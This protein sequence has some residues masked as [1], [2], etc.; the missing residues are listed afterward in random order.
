[1]SIPP[2]PGDLGRRLL[3]SVVDD[4]ARS[5]P[6]R[7]L[8]SMPKTRSPRDGFQDITAV[9]FSQAVDRCAWYL[10]KQL[11][12]G[13]GFPT[14]LYIGPQDLV[15]AILILASIKVGYKLLL[16]SPRNTLEAHVHL[17]KETGCGTMLVPTGFP[18]P[19]IGKI[20]ETTGIRR[21]DLPGA[22]HWLCDEAVEAYP[23]HKTYEEARLEPW[24]ALHTSGST[25]MPKPIIQ[26]HA[27]Y[28]P[29]DAYTAL[30][31]LGLPRTFP[32]FPEG[33]RVYLGFPLF[34]CGGLFV[35]LPCSIFGNF[36]VVLGPFPPSSEVIQQ[37]HDHGNVEE[38]LIPPSSLADM[39]KDPTYIEGLSRLNRITT[40]GGPLPREVGNTISS[41]TGLANILGSTEA[42][43]IPLEVIDRE[44][45]AYMRVSP[46]YGAEF[47][48]VSEDLYEQVIVRRPELEPYQGVFGTFP[49]LQEWPMKDLYSKHPTKEGLWLY[50][51]RTDDIIVFSTGEKLN[52]LDMEDII[53]AHSAV[54]GAVICGTGH[55]QSSLLVETA[56][57]STEAA[58]RA[59]LLE[60]IW[61]FIEKANKHSP[62]HGRIQRDMVLFTTADRPMLRAGKGTV[63]RQATVDLY[64]ADLDKLYASSKTELPDE[65]GIKPMGETVGAA[66]AVK[67][68]ISNAT[69]I[70][71]N[72]VAADANLFD[73]GLDSLQVINITKNINKY[74]VS[75]GKPSSM[76]PRLVYAEPTVAAISNAVAALRKGDH[77]TGTSG[78]SAVEKMLSL[79][80]SNSS[81]LPIN[82]RPPQQQPEELTVLLTGST[83]SLGSYIL[84][85]LVRNSNVAQVFCL[86]R[87][88]GSHERLQK[89]QA[90][91]GLN[92]LPNKVSCIEGDLSKDYFG[93]TAKDY[94]TLLSSVSVIIH[95]AWLLNF[96]A[97]LES[98]IPFV[99]ST[100]KLVDFSAHSRFGA[101]VFFISSLSSVAKYH[102]VY[103]SRDRVPEDII[104]DWRVAYD[105]PYGQSKFV[106]ER[107]LD[108]AAKIAGVP[109]AVC[110]VGQIAGPT[111]AAG[112]WPKHEWLPSLVASSKY[113]GKL[114]GSLGKLERVD[115]IP[116][117]LLGSTISELALA[118]HSAIEA[119]Q[120]SGAVVYHTVNPKATSWAELVPVVLAALGG[121]S[122]VQVV[123]LE[124]WLEAL[125][126][127]ESKTADIA[128]N[129]ALKLM[130]FF[131]DLRNGSAPNLDTKRTARSSSSLAGL[132]SV[133]PAWMENWTR[134]WEL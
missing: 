69:D 37:I 88:P 81:N 35:L 11:G 32:W 52:P 59:R 76:S 8:Y 22:A 94:K 28:S 4:I 61:P 110:R 96:T 2:P 26:S 114:P 90:A 71:L 58:E 42:G 51:G 27:S 100:R 45:W 133:Q 111:M 119:M 9:Q 6:S 82:D 89:V 128:V 92:A 78:K 13:A 34:H 113:L 85:S 46:V 86:N 107:I 10:H 109:T 38:S 49:H 31:S 108:T 103:P 123:S 72:E 121:T 12:Q 14:V 66:D 98:F 84:D 120:P 77:P 101:R 17:V 44:D 36:T 56:E 126:D 24:V 25:G 79:Y 15:Y 130:D 132:S 134:Q 80:E 43:L 50:R 18:L 91:K 16:N 53:Q 21:V 70:N 116:V 5:D 117:D 60:E 105:T 87:G 104:E 93:L 57:P 122:N 65:D 127:S 40:G 20:I 63:Q 29:V 131:K 48:Q 95:A 99:T 102:T 54:K 124:A 39:A 30:P 33:S 115:W 55:F 67:I 125:R 7:V 41:R 83:G 62:S 19:V 23:Y 68:I 74:L 3:P 1:M 106:S 97:P 47:R 64:K 118:S 73:F 129:P 75:L 112:I